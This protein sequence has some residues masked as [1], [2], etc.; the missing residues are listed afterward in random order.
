MLKSV[1]SLSVLCYLARSLLYFAVLFF[2][3]QRSGKKE[4][5][6]VIR[7]I[8]TW[9]GDA[10][11]LPTLFAKLREG[12]SQ[13]AVLMFNV[14]AVGA[15]VDKDPFT[16]ADTTRVVFGEAAILPLLFCRRLAFEY[17]GSRL[18][19]HQF[20]ALA[21]K[22]VAHIACQWGSLWI[23]HLFA[24]NMCHSTRLWINTNL[25]ICPS[26]HSSFLA[27][28]LHKKSSKLPVL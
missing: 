6:I 23:R 5:G 28:L 11:H 18:C 8:A 10:G 7:T 21:A 16:L 20:P 27:I 14:V 12:C 17:P 15:V 22:L 1:F 13:A 9:A 3:G 2:R 24:V 19:A 4:G 25:K 26:C